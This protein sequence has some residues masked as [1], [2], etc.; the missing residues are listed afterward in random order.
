MGIYEELV[1][2]GLIA[3][4]TNEDSCPDN[5]S[6]RATYFSCTAGTT[7]LSGSITSAGPPVACRPRAFFLRA[8][9]SKGRNRTRH[10]ASRTEVHV[11]RFISGWEE[12]VT[13]IRLTF[14]M[15]RLL[16]IK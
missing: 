14:Q 7:I 4:V 15:F 1:A 12:F 5:D 11:K 16:T 9:P 13:K 2:R 10:K 8:F 3:Q 6:T